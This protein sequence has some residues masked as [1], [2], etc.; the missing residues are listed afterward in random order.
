MTPM[1][2]FLKKGNLKSE[3]HL[4]NNLAYISRR[5][6]IVLQSLNF[7]SSKG[8]RDVLDMFTEF[9]ASYG[10]TQSR[11]LAHSLILA[12]PKDE[13]V[14]ALLKSQGQEATKENIKIIHDVLVRSF[15]KENGLKNHL[16]VWAVHY[17]KKG[18]PHAHVVYHSMDMISGR[19]LTYHNHDQ[20][21]DYIRVW[22]KNWINGCRKM[23]FEVIEKKFPNSRSQPIADIKRTSCRRKEVAAVLEKA[24]ISSPN[25]TSL[26]SEMS[27]QNFQI[28]I[29]N[30]NSESWLTISTLNSKNEIRRFSSNRLQLSETSRLLIQ[31]YISLENIPQTKT[32]RRTRPMFTRF[33][34]ALARNFSNRIRRNPELH[35]AIRSKKAT[36]DM[37]KSEGLHTHVSSILKMKTKPQGLDVLASLM[38]ETIISQLLAN[39]EPIQKRKEPKPIRI[40]ERERDVYP[41]RSR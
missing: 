7:D 30:R 35:S 23:G 32:K 37:L 12:L 28:K 26:K 11:R 6:S 5:D 24:L 39:F 18:N 36:L 3:S 25:F 34:A 27:K 9:S 22:K 21:D 19:K 13:A 17:D 8:H 20:S 4:A 16:H 31:G 29:T 41:S 1:I 40:I 10:L 2:G 38:G 14:A 15:L 33:D